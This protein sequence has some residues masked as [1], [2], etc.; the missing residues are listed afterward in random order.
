MIP[1]PFIEKLSPS[2]TYLQFQFGLKSRFHDL[3]SISG[4]S[5]QIHWSVFPSIY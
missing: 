3:K 5:I 1:V 4:F 2:P